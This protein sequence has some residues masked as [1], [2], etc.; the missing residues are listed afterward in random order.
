M[1]TIK[2]FIN[3]LYTVVGRKLNI[4]ATNTLIKI[5][6]IISAFVAKKIQIKYNLFF[7][8]YDQVNIY[9]KYTWKDFECTKNVFE[10]T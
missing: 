1:I 10:R 4:F 3:D 7:I 8:I 6:V 5:L 2:K 9:V